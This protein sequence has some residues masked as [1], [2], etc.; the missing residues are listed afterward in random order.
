[1]KQTFTAGLYMLVLVWL[2]QRM[3]E[4]MPDRQ[5][6]VIFGAMAGLGLAL[7]HRS[8]RT[9]GG[10]GGTAVAVGGAGIVGTLVGGIAKCI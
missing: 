10:I 5:G 6:W 3:F 8:P 4:V 7:G 2:L 9:D 1:M